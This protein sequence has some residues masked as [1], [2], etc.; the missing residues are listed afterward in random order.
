MPESG[1]PRRTPSAARATYEKQTAAG[2]LRH[3]SGTTAR[4]AASL[5]NGREGSAA[6]AAQEAHLSLPPRP[7]PRRPRRNP[8]A[9]GEEHVPAPTPA[10]SRQQCRSRPDAVASRCPAGRV[11]R[12]PGN[13][14]NAN[15]PKNHAPGSPPNFIRP[16]MLV[17]GLVVAG[18]A[19]G[20]CGG[21][22]RDGALDVVGAGSG[23]PASQ[24]KCNGSQRPDRNSAGCSFQQVEVGV[25][26]D[27]RPLAGR[28]ARPGRQWPRGEP[29]RS[30]LLSC[31]LP[32]SPRSSVSGHT[33]GGP[34]QWPAHSGRAVPASAPRSV[35]AS[36]AGNAT[37]NILCL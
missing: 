33:S 8:R 2:A 34:Q 15:G 13:A 18:P 14:R 6:Q 12:R 22:V 25:V 11:R 29:A 5:A 20:R 7:A 16:R 19:R 26:W 31:Q 36:L 28:P 27:L 3:Q 17:R 10:A 23:R 24:R 30:K 1:R 35:H 21:P 37:I 9:Q 32:R 4:T